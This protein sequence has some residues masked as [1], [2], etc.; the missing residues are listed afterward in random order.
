M[1]ARSTASEPAPLS[2]RAA[3]ALLQL[4]VLLWGPALLGKSIT[5]GARVLVFYRVL[6]VAVIMAVLM[7]RQNLGFSVSRRTFAELVG[8]GTCVALHWI[9]LSLIHI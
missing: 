7:K 5:V 8:A 9:T 3:H 4:T 1:T 6:V 2:T